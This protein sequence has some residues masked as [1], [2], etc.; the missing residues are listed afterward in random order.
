MPSPMETLFRIHDSPVPTH[1]TFG[2]LGSIATAPIDCTGCLSKTGLNVV[3]PLT[4]FQTPPLAAPTYTVSR[5]PSL[6]ASTAAILP[7]MVAEPMFRA[8]NPDIVWGSIVARGGISCPFAIVPPARRTQARY[9]RTKCVG[10]VF[11]EVSFSDIIL[12]SDWRAWP[13]SRSGRCR[14]AHSP[15]WHHR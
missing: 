11:I 2:L 9:K 4:D 8:P 13:A 14:V 3:P 7:L 12:R 1:T 6:T 5:L 15:V 10:T